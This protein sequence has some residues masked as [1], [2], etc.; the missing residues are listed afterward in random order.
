MLPPDAPSESK[1]GAGDAE[2]TSQALVA[3]DSKEIPIFEASVTGSL[4]EGEILSDLVQ[5]L[6]NVQTLSS[7]EGA[8]VE[9][10]NHPFAVVVTQDCDVMQDFTVRS[11]N[12]TETLPN[13]LFCEVIAAEDLR[14]AVKASGLG[15]QDWKHLKQN[16]LERYH[17]LES[18]PA[19]EDAVGNGLPALGVDFKRYFTLPTEE[20]YFR[21]SSGEAQRRCRLIAP[22]AQHLRARFFNYHSRV[23]L[24]RNHQTN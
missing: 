23:A 16:Q 12:S 10:K 11:E 18:A 19:A 24:P 6:L 14:G 1:V 4:R 22:Y 13:V 9:L 7:P 17:Y 8:I 15:S 3:A 21:I 2:T 5:A 20:V